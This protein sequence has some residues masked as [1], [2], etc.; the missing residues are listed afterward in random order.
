MAAKY[1][2]S[3]IENFIEERKHLPPDFGIPIRLKDKPGQQERDVDVEGEYGHSF[4]LIMRQ[5]K[6]NPLDFSVIV[7]VVPVGSNQVFKLRRY[8]GF[9]H[10]HTNKIERDSFYAYHI[11]YAT[12]RYQEL[13]LKEEYYAEPTDRY[14]EFNE[15]LTCALEDCG[16][17]IPEDDQMTMFGG[18]LS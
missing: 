11:H 4:K 7:A 3:E 13:G 15:A 16:F 2:D 17:D 14:S 12:Q 18:G 1:T 6:S 9:S 8:N 10:E 5:N